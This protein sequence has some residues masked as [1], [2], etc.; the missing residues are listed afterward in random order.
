MRVAPPVISM[1]LSATE[2]PGVD[3]RC[4]LVTGASSGVGRECSILLANL[5]ATVILSGRDS[6]RL[7]ETLRKMP[8]AG[9]VKAEAD[10]NKTDFLPWLED[11]LNNAGMGLSGV[12]HCAGSH[13]FRPLRGFRAADFLEILEQS[14][15]KTAE[16]FFAVSR[17]KKRAPSCSLAVMTSVSAS[18]AVPGNALYGSARAAVESLCRSFA[19]EFAPLGIRCNAVR[20]GFMEGGAMSGKG[21]SMLGKTGCENITASYP[22]GLGRVEDAA[23]A[24]VFLLGT[25]SRWIT[26]SVLNV[27]GGY[28]ARGI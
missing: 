3:G 21:A 14:P 24:L 25:A 9:H 5:G 26:G 20:A 11:I 13:N 18:H 8:G 19:V 16:L 17:L 6:Q 7:D 28:A 1:P 15:L 23:N 4:F 2:Y 10:L 22:L 27:D 12:A